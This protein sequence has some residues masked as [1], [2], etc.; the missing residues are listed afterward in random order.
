ML[1]LKLLS[2]SL[3]SARKNIHLVHISSDFILMETK[4]NLYTENDL[5]NPSSY[6]GLSKLK[7]ESTS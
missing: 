5:P 6:Y 4:N 1:T 7:S 2:I 3:K